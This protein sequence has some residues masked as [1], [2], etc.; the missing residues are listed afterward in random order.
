MRKTGLTR[1]IRGIRRKSGIKPKKPSKGEVP[2]WLKCVPEGQHGSGTLQKRLWRLTS[3]YCRIRDWHKFGGKCV[4]TG[5]YLETWN[6][7][8]GGHFKSWQ[9]CNG[10]YKFHP[11]N[12]HLQ[13]AWSNSWGDKDDWQQFEEEL[14]RRY[15]EQHLLK[16]E[17]QNGS[18]Q[19]RITPAMVR[20]DIELKISLIAQLP[21]KPPY[22]NRLI[23]L[24]GNTETDPTTLQA[25]NEME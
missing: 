10:M 22:W 17:V 7:G 1:P 25:E 19:A 18:T 21:E 20:Q 5:K 11:D 4:A 13:T 8:Q 12:I 16:I 14:I 23:K 24:K 6:H 9:K 15:G 2:I 3:D